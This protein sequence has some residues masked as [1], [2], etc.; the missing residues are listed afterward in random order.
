MPYAEGHTYY[1]ADSHVMEIDD[2]LPQ[3]AD[4]DGRVNWDSLMDQQR[5]YLERGY[6]RS[7]EML[8]LVRWGEDAPRQ[9]ALQA[10]GQ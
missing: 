2:G 7:P 8:D 6:L 4:P 9:A 5:F 3:Y 1:D 10:L